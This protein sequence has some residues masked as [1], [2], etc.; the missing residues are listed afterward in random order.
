[1]NYKQ[2]NVWQESMKLAVMSFRI[3]D[4]CSGYLF[5]QIRKSSVSIPS[6]IAEGLTR[7]YK[8][9]KLLFINISLS[10]LAE[11]ETQ[12]ILAQN[13]NYLNDDCAYLDQV[14]K[15]KKLILG[16]IIAIKKT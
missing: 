4:N 1:M 7:M 13:L 3:T 9:Q 11:L 6:N 2:L 10:S 16:T 8:K 15:V 12:F 5:D 14:Y